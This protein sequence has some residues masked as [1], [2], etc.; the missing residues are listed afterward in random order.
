MLPKRKLIRRIGLMLLFALIYITQQAQAANRNYYQIKIYHLKNKAQEQL[1]DSYLKDF[2]LPKLHTMGIKNIGV[3]KTLETDTADRR[4]Y[5]FIHFATWKKMEYF[6]ENVSR[7]VAKTGREYVDAN[8][9]TPPYSRMET[10]ILNAFMT[11]P[12]PALPK[13]TAN[14]TDRIYELRSYES[15]TEQYHRNKVSMFNSG[16]TDLFD[17]LGF[18]SVFYGS[19]VAG[20]RMP[21]L[22][23]M[24]AFNSKEDRD[25]HWAAFSSDTQWKTLSGM[26]EYQNNVSKSDVIFLQPAEYSDF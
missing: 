2:Y 3:F 11:R 13:L 26:P 6:D 19:V 10:I 21:N 20:C 15:V 25:K 5:V 24:T 16:E 7:D 18:N 12:V 22:M 23:Y 8:Y 14:K 9:K 4:I 1:V 17:R